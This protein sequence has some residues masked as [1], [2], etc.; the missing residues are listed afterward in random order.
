MNAI[1]RLTS[2]V[3]TISTR[4]LKNK[5]NYSSTLK[6]YIYLVIVI[7]FYERASSKSTM[8]FSLNKSEK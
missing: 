1:L 6:S 2:Q 3:S 8:I 7:S 4:T 5:N